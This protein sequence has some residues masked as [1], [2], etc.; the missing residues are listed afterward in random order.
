MSEKK[1]PESEIFS[2]T[3]LPELNK[4]DIFTTTVYTK[5]ITHTHKLGPQL[6]PI[7]L[8]AGVPQTPSC[9]FSSCS[10]PGWVGYTPGGG[11]CKNQEKWWTRQATTKLQGYRAYEQ[12]LAAALTLFDYGRHNR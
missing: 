6:T 5:A 10:N 3:T 7:K 12:Y 9:Y 1:Q 8:A 2:H 4:L 11:S